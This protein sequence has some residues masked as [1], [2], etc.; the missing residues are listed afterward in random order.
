MR[1][2]AHDC[3]SGGRIGARSS[4]RALTTGG[5]R[6]PIS[7]AH[8]ASPSGMGVMGPVMGPMRNLPLVLMIKSEDFHS[9]PGSATT[10]AGESLLTEVDQAISDSGDE[11]ERLGIERSGSSSRGIDPPSVIAPIFGAWSAASFPVAQPDTLASMIANRTK[12]AGPLPALR[13]PLV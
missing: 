13:A 3:R 10:L 12:K 2:Y 6:L 8:I 5:L 1:W 11:A 7:G 4:P 9:K